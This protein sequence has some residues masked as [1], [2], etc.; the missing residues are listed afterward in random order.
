MNV[1][2][3]NGREEIEPKFLF[4]FLRYKYMVKR[5]SVDIQLK[6]QAHVITNISSN[7]TLRL[8]SVLVHMQ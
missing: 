3:C 5:N 8:R 1:A 4:P 6:E 2:G 7:S